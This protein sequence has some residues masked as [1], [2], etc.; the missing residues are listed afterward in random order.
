ML[1]GGDDAGFEGVGRHGRRVA[2]ADF[3][4]LHRLAD[5][6]LDRLGG[7]RGFQRELDDTDGIRFV[8]RHEHAGGE[9]VARGRGFDQ[10]ARH[11]VAE[12][13]RG[14]L[15]RPAEREDVPVQQ[16]GDEAV[17]V[18]GNHALEGVL[19]PEHGVPDRP[20]H[21]RRVFSLAAFGLV[22]LERG[23]SEIHQRKDVAQ[24]RGELLLALEVAAHDEHR[25]VGEEGEGRREARQLL[26]VAP[27]LRR[28]V[29]WHRGEIGSGEA[30]APGA[31]AARPDEPQVGGESGIEIAQ[32]FYRIRIPRRRH[33]LQH[34]R[35][36]ADRALAEDDQAARQDVGALDRDRH[37]HLLVGAAHEVVGAE[38]DALA[39]ED[40]HGVVDHLARTLG[41]VVL[42]DGGDHRGFLAEVD[43]AGR[44]GARRV[45]RVKVAAHA[46]QRLLDALEAAD[47]GLELAADAGVGAG[48]AH[49]ELGHA[50]VGRGQ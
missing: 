7:H 9:A 36:A 41:D 16:G 28:H 32:A 23:R 2:G 17:R 37:R 21:Q 11:L 5:A 14:H 46:C 31:E 22:A 27:R 8:P 39:A 34:V 40:V 19:H 15:V 44:H 18:V 20:V 25:N 6:Q 35:V 47:G 24:A 49:R 26:V 12:L 43:G 48:G 33:F 10:Q 3:S 50:G 13:V 30:H 45:H 29:R 4:F 38:A 1:L 42:D